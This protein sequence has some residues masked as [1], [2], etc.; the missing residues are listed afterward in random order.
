MA[1]LEIL[2]T[3]LHNTRTR[4]SIRIVINLTKNM[5]SLKKKFKL[6]LYI[7]HRKR[8][9]PQNKKEMGKI[10]YLKITCKKNGLR[11]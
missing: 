4:N 2:L 1:Q 9:T 6:N 10:H 3:H 11:S 8:T 5:K 7:P